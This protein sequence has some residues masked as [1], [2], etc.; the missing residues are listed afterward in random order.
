MAYFLPPSMVLFTPHP[1]PVKVYPV[2]PGFS[3]PTQGGCDGSS[4]PPACR[5]PLPQPGP[6]L[7]WPLAGL[8]YTIYLTFYFGFPYPLQSQPETPALH[9][10]LPWPG[11]SAPW[12][13]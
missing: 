10:L 9:T 11:V 5:G 4:D 12:P 2:L 1:F 8:L 3:L 7:A 6:A 13:W